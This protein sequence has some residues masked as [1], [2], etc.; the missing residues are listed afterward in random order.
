MIKEVIIVEGKEDISAIKRAVDAEVIKT[1]GYYIGKETL[2]KIRTAYERTGI[3]IFT[4]PDYAGERI[5]EKLS[6]IFKES[7]HAF[8][9]REEATVND[10]IGI[11]NA[12]PEDIIKAL[13]K[14]RVEKIDRLPQFTKSELVKHGLI[15]SENSFN[16]RLKLG[17]TLGI[18]YAN[19]KQL[20]K[21]LN[22]YGVT[23]EEFY[24]G[25]EE[26]EN[27]R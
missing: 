26:I 27:G 7:K 16:K 13:E 18:G 2:D 21:R 11:E 25:I 6:K 14:A 5:R 4:D 22:N 1:N 20:L 19:G 23:R 10:D 12:K 9:S 3:I 17:I 15:G 8:I 24:K